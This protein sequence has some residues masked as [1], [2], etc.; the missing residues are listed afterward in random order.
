VPAVP[1]C[2]ADPPRDTLI[3][4]EAGVVKVKRKKRPR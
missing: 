2:V 1:V 4:T 3:M